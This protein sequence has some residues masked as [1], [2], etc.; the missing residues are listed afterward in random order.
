M[1]VFVA[2]VGLLAIVAIWSIRARYI[3]AAPRAVMASPKAARAVSRRF[4]FKRKSTRHPAETID[5]PVIAVG[6]L[7]V[8]FFELGD[9]PTRG[10][11]AALGDALAQE[12][13]LSAT[14]ADELMS[15]GHW[16]VTEIRD[17]ET[18]IARIGRRLYRLDGGANFSQLMTVIREITTAGFGMSRR[19]SHALDAL[20]T[21][22]HIG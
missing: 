21:V 14:E 13:A 9:H 6:A 5:D 12:F 1:P 17:P 10:Q 2:S 22:F 19:Q 15:I 7:A 3:A 11:K 18:A 8:A 4:K 16:L 20:R